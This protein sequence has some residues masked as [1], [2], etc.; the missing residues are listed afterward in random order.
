MH[1]YIDMTGSQYLT[2][3]AQQQQQD[4]IQVDSSLPYRRTSSSGP[5]PAVAYSTTDLTPSS[6][7]SSFNIPATTD[8][9][10]LT[11]VSS[12]GSPP[13]HQRLPKTTCGYYPSQTSIA[14]QPTPP[15]TSR[16]YYSYDINPSSQASSPMT[17]HPQ[18]TQP[19]L[20]VNNYA[21]S[22]PRDGSVPDFVPYYGSYGVSESSAPE[23]NIPEY[24]QH[25]FLP[26]IMDVDPAP[27]WMRHANMNVNAANYPRPIA[28]SQTPILAQPDPSVFRGHRS[29]NIEDL[30]DPAMTARMRELQQNGLY[31]RARSAPGPKQKGARRNQP[32][33]Q[34]RGAK[35]TTPSSARYDRQD[36]Q[37]SVTQGSQ[38]SPPQTLGREPEEE[39]FYVDS[40]PEDEKYVFE[41]RKQYTDKKGKGMWDA[42]IGDFEKKYQRVE[43]AALQMKVTR[44]VS[45]YA[46]WPE[47]ENEALRK[48]FEK[49]HNEIWSRVLLHMKEFGGCKVWNWKEQNIESRAVFLGLVEPVVDD[50]TK[51]RKRRQRV[52]G[53]RKVS[54]QAQAHELHVIDYA[55]GLGA[56]IPSYGAHPVFQGTRRPSYEMPLEDFV[57]PPPQFTDEQK[58]EI[59]ESIFKDRPLEIEETPEPGSNMEH[60][61]TQADM[62]LESN[63]DEISDINTQGSQRIARQARD[64]MLQQQNR[65]H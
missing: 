19:G 38:T 7:V 11:P 5:P 12:A 14:Q 42:I 6:A 35:R 10:L 21:N 9:T 45:K 62:K 50:K 55:N 2:S 17:V 48:G 18:G 20:D 44:G 49:A 65:H 32:P 59:I 43:K 54:A 36:S 58:S 23:H 56:Q 15:Q 61:Y 24:A 46:A 28:P 63:M 13:L 51:I 4:S 64:R 16:M 47:F 40:A 30:R 60:E 1:I 41:L 39:L 31:D 53:Q 27:V 57:E 34:R 25:P 3:G 37:A 22:S 52:P 33:K 26:N 8:S 29:Q